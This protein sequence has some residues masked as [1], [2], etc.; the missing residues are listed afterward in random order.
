MAGLSHVRRW[1]R[2]VSGHRVAS[3]ALSSTWSFLSV[4][5]F[6][7]ARA[8]CHL[9]LPCV[10]KQGP[11]GRWP[12]GHGSEAPPMVRGPL[13]KSREAA[14]LISEMFVFSAAFVVRLS[15]TTL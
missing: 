2:W 8:G 11:G 7:L 15:R 3:A 6:L 4:S 5:R 12:S 10:T 14:A 1:V 13:K 9:C